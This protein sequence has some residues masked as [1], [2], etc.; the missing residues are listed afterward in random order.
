M[1]KIHRLIGSLTVLI[2]LSTGFYM[3]ANFPGLYEENEAIRFMYRA[4]HIYILLAG[5]LNIAIGTYFI[6]TP[7]KWMKNLQIVGSSALLIAPVLLVSAF[8]WNRKPLHA[9]DLLPRTVFLPWRSERYA[10]Y[11]TGSP[12]NHKSKYI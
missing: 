11:P 9:K 2:F 6:F 4:N 7:K 10:M 12:K 8:F 3:R 1:N 5:L